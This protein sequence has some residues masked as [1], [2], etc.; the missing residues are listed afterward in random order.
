MECRGGSVGRDGKERED[1]NRRGRSLPAAASIPSCCSSAAFPP[2][3]SAPCHRL[4]TPPT[5]PPSCPPYPTPAPEQLRVQLGHCIR[6]LKQLWPAG[7]V[8]ASLLHSNPEYGAP[9]GSPGDQPAGLAAMAAAAASGL[10]S[11]DG[12]PDVPG[13]QRRCVPRADQFA[14]GGWARSGRCGGCVVTALV[15]AQKRSH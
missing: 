12:D 4:L 13:T 3:P 10:E 9:N 2:C 15:L 7:C 5:H 8:I 14:V 1:A 11:G 6:R